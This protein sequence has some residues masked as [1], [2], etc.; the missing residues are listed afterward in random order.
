MS[1][2]AAAETAE[3]ANQREGFACNPRYGYQPVALVPAQDVPLLPKPEYKTW[4]AFPKMAMDR[5][6]S[7]EVHALLELNAEGRVERV[8]IVSETPRGCLFAEATIE[9]FKRWR[10]APGNAGLYSAT[11]TFNIE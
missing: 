9:A 6:T 2:P 3:P 11:M 4:P 10:F 8:D 5:V 1:K 7:G